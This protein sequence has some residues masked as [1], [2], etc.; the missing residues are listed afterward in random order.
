MAAAELA[1]IFTTP[2]IVEIPSEPVETDD[3]HKNML[4]NA[5]RSLV[6]TELKCQVCNDKSGSPLPDGK[7]VKVLTSFYAGPG[8]SPWDAMLNN[9]GYLV[10]EN[11]ECQ[12]II[13]EMA[14]KFSAAC[15]ALG[16]AGISRSRLG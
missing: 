16:I 3:E 4:K 1:K 2:K 12:S 13:E 9:I 6:C 8:I 15:K 7:V 5:P 10:C 14:K 11:P